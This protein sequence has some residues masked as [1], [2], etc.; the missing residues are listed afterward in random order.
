MTAKA[1]SLHTKV[2]VRLMKRMGPTLEVK[3]PGMETAKT[4]KALTLKAPM[5]EVTVTAEG[6]SNKTEESVPA[7]QKLT[8]RFQHKWCHWQKRPKEAPQ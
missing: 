5:T 2:T 1:V 8:L 6:T 7:L 3:P 4:E